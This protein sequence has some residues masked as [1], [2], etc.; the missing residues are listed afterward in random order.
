MS[1]KNYINRPR[2][3]TEGSELNAKQREQAMN[4]SNA[5]LKAATATALAGL[6]GGAMAMGALADA[7]KRRRDAAMKPGSDVKPIRPDNQ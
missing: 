1:D 3:V 5:V 7:K 4:V 6:G 2:K